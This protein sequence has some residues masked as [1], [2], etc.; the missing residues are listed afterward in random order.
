[1]ALMIPNLRKSTYHGI[2]EGGQWVEEEEGKEEQENFLR[3]QWFS[4]LDMQMKWDRND[5]LVCMYRKEGQWLKYTDRQ[6][7]HRPTTL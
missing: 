7:T 3:I 6:S 1:M 5:L 4:F 2:G